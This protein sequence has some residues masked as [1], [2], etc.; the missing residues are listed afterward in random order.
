MQVELSA[1]KQQDSS[2]WFVRKQN[3]RSVETILYRL[4]RSVVDLYAR[5]M[6]KMDVQW[7]APLPDGPKILAANHPTTTDPFLLMLLAS[8]PVSVL[9]TEGCF[10][11]PVFGRILS[12][13]GHVPVVRNSGGNTVEVAGRLLAEGRTVAIFPEGAISLADGG[14]HRPRSGVARLAMSSGA[15]V[16]PVGIG[17]DR[18]RIRRIE[19]EVDSKAEVIT[20][21]LRGPYAMTVGWPLRFEGNVDDW[22]YV[23]SVSGQIMG[24]IAGLARESDRRVALA[25][26][27]ASQSGVTPVEAL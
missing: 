11:I 17:L 2:N 16:I 6:L 9:V 21:Y 24:R 8:E 14:F 13:S 22:A 3:L 23:R 19:T 10:E 20:W 1:K 5:L 25:P 12:E 18:Q 26:I 7:H 27:A 15:P 4:G